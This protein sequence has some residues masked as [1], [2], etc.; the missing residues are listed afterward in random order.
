MNQILVIISLLIV[1]TCV[2]AQGVEGIVFD[3]NREPIP[4]ASVSVIAAED[5]A[6][7]TGTTTDENGKFHIDCNTSEKLLKVSFVGYKQG[8]GSYQEMSVTYSIPIVIGGH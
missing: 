5:S 7:V 1:A 2:K 6:Y 4:F 3:E 8:I